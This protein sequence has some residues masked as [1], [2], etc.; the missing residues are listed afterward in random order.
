MQRLDKLSAALTLVMMAGVFGVVAHVFF[1]HVDAAPPISTDDALA[2]ISYVMLE[3]G[4]NGFLA[5]PLQASGT[6]VDRTSGFFNYGPW[7]FWFGAALSWLFGFSVKLMRFIHP[8]MLFLISVAACAAFRRDL[9]AAGLLFTFLTAHVFLVSHW[10]MVRPDVMVSFFVFLAAVFAG[11]AMLDN[12][13]WP[14]AA[15]GFFAG[16]APVVHM[17]AWAVAPGLV[18]VWL[19]WYVTE[20]VAAQRATGDTARTS[21]R[22]WTAFL[23]ALGGGIASGLVFLWAADF[24]LAEIV[25][26]YLWY[27]KG[28]HEPSPYVLTLRKHLDMAL[29]PFGGIERGYATLAFCY[30]AG[31]AGM[32]ALPMLF[33][34]SSRRSWALIAPPMTLTLA[35]LASLGL[36]NNWHSGY[37]I[38]VQLGPLWVL[39]ATTAA[40][41]AAARGRWPRL[42]AASA[43]SATVLLSAFVAMKITAYAGTKWNWTAYAE[44]SVP[45]SRFYE[46]AIAPMPEG[47][48]AF[49]T[50]TFGMESGGRIQLVQFGEGVLAAERAGEKRRREIRPD[51]LLLGNYEPTFWIISALKAANQFQAMA[52]M[53]EVFPDTIW[54]PVKVVNAHPYGHVSLFARRIGADSTEPEAAYSDGVHSNWL[55]RAAETISGDLFTPAP[56]VRFTLRMGG[57]TE[58]RADASMSAEL[59]EG[60]YLVNVGLDGDGPD[61]YGM[62]AASP[63]DHVI[64]T[65]S[66]DQGFQS[67]T[68]TPY[69]RGARRGALLV[70]HRGGRL[71]IS[72]LGAE[73]GFRVESVKRLAEPVEPEP[74]R[75]PVPPMT[76]WE[77]VTAGSGEAL[78]VSAEAITVVGDASRY[79]YQLQSPLIDVPTH[80][81]I[82]VTITINAENGEV[83][84]GALDG[85]GARW[86]AAPER[87]GRIT[88][89][90][91][92]ETR[93][94]LVIANMND[95]P[96]TG[97]ARFTARRGEIS[98]IP[99]EELYMDR[100]IA[101]VDGEGDGCATK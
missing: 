56:P 100:L 68:M 15:A 40:V 101:C 66:S 50:V 29:A 86:L 44:K 95:A 52:R 2:N 46:E 31:L 88:F 54:E 17:I 96:L 92:D 20:A 63:T 89:N 3:H 49:G 77:V 57:T 11:K 39:S 48:R 28:H 41:F 12:T 98:F 37:V 6:P 71:Y 9:P 25:D 64:E 30:A 8:L 79:G 59:P 90:T 62:L 70:P 22:P 43:F 80:A 51:Y 18:M 45:F 74:E 81:R 60:V 7:Y 65:Y 24:R 87:D 27:A 97:Q 67:F 85:S 93:F 76:E 35:Y 61:S 34:G 21:A 69:F 14:W 73:N 1:G 94:R 10:P 33:P 32:I 58:G 91:G 83:G 55:S 19:F 47:A 23:A 53:A 36:Y 78:A 13:V 26:F 99:G 4:R 84:L 42:G 82:T 72:Q 5:S 38:L 16:S 75:L